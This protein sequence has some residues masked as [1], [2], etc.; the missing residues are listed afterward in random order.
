VPGVV[1]YIFSYRKVGTLPWTSLFVNNAPETLATNLQPNST[2][3]YTVQSGCRHNN[4]LAISL[5]LAYRQ[6]VTLPKICPPVA[7]SNVQVQYLSV[8]KMQA[9]CPPG[10]EAYVWRLRRVGAES[11]TDSISLDTPVWTIPN[12]RFPEQ[13]E[14]QVKQKCIAGNWSAWS[15]SKKF[16]TPELAC[17]K[18]DLRNIKILVIGDNVQFL[19]L[20]GQFTRYHWRY[21][22]LGDS[23]WAVIPDS[24]FQQGL[25]LD[26]AANYEVALQVSCANGESSEWSES[27]MFF[28]PCPKIKDNEIVMKELNAHY[29]HIACASPSIDGYHWRYRQVGKPWWEKEVFSLNEE[30]LFDKLAGEK[31]YEFQVRRSCSDFD[32]A[33]S[34]TLFFST[35]PLQSLSSCTLTP[36]QI[37][38]KEVESGKIELTCS[39]AAKKYFWTYRKQDASDWAAQLPSTTGMINFDRLAYG[40]AYIIGVRAI[41]LAGD[42]TDWVYLSYYPSCSDIKVTDVKIETPTDKSVLL[43]CTNYNFST[44]EWR[45]RSYGSTDN[46][47]YAAGNDLKIT[48]L[49]EKLYEV[50]VRGFC[51]QIGTWTPWSSLYQFSVGICKLPS[52]LVFVPKFIDATTVDIL[53][54]SNSSDWKA[55]HYKWSYRELGRRNWIDTIITEE[56]S[57]S[58]FDL[59]PGARYELKVEVICFAGTPSSFVYSNYITMPTGCFVPTLDRVKVGRI[60]QT[61]AFIELDYNLYLPFTISYRVKGSQTAF[62]TIDGLRGIVPNLTGLIPA[63][64]YEM[65]VGINCNGTIL[66]TPAIYFRT[67]SCDIPY[68]GAV[69]VN[70]INLDYIEA[71]VEFH[72]FHPASSGLNY[73]WKYKLKNSTNWDSISTGNQNTL[74][75]EGLQPESSY[76]LKVVLHCPNSY[77]DSIQFSTSFKTVLDKCSSIEGSENVINR[78]DTNYKQ[79]FITCT[80]PSEF[81]YSIRFWIRF[82]Q[83]VT[84]NYWEFAVSDSL[85]C[86]RANF[87]VNPY[88]GQKF[89]YQ[90]RILCPD[91]NYSPWSDTIFLDFKN[92]QFTADLA[93]GQIDLSAL[94]NSLLKKLQLW[95]NPSS[96]HFNLLI[97]PGVTGDLQLTVLSADG[98]KILAKQLEDYDQGPLGIDLSSQPS[99]VYF[100][101]VQAGQKVYTERIVIGAGN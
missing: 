52:S 20:E 35:P 96:G 53:L 47:I 57:L 64:E 94:E 74:Y 86:G 32:G 55:A 2:Y 16:F 97:P 78:Y 69:V 9:T 13:Y 29:A 72:N 40:V 33:F 5:V 51:Q 23:V 101:R 100:V 87:S 61:S 79:Y 41:C 15:S 26:Q 83:E 91:G 1:F 44:Y 3:E 76:D 98:R 67:K 80:L 73:I 62:Q 48:Q 54:E 93:K 75:L 22:I 30:V 10:A 14:I 50:Q 99:G 45:Y 85:N 92:D 60:T 63:T 68:A 71:K 43:K 90:A 49:I 12:L 34:D 58:L 25:V 19:Y 4:E 38:I 8:R 27:K 56:T 81:Y 31:T 89:Y 18:P 70:S 88:E 39:L 11:W 7:Y 84:N 65:V 6:F 28:W 37:N 17:P 21:R 66:Q 95:P 36:D 82:D 24:V 77:A 59:I 42:S 46:W